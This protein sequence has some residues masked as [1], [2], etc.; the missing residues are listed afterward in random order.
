MKIKNA[1]K[2]TNNARKLDHKKTARRQGA[3]QKSTISQKKSEK[4]CANN[5]I[6]ACK[7]RVSML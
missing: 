4:N 5:T 6:F 7:E 1:Q 2:A 3:Q